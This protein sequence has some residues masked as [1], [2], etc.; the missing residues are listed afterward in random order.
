V[1]DNLA[2]NNNNN[3]YIK[4]VE[5]FFEWKFVFYDKITFSFFFA[6]LW[7]KTY[8]FDVSNEKNKYLYTPRIHTIKINK[9]AHMKSKLKKKIVMTFVEVFVYIKCHRKIKYYIY[10]DNEP[11]YSKTNT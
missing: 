4:C 8:S 2:D 9:P 10:F 1:F 3:A 7:L 5:F 6:A 11:T